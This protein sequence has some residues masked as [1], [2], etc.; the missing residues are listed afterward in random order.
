[1]S[2]AT[3]VNLPPFQETKKN[4]QICMLQHIRCKTCGRT[5]RQHEEK[6]VREPAAQGAIAKGK[7]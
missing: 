7:R 1:M 5:R 6:L 2:V 4:I 3:Y